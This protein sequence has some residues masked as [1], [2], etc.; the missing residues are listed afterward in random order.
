[1]VNKKKQ[2]SKST[3]RASPGK[4]KID[5]K[6]YKMMHTIFGKVDIP[7]SHPKYKSID[8]P[9]T[10][11]PAL[12]D[13]KKE[14][15]MGDE[16]KMLKWLAKQPL[17]WVDDD[18]EKNYLTLEGASYDHSTFGIASRQWD[19]EEAME[20][21]K[22]K[23]IRSTSRVSIPEVYESETEEVYDIL[24]DANF[25]GVINDLNN[26]EKKAII[27]LRREHPRMAGYRIMD[28]FVKKYPKM[29]RRLRKIMGDDD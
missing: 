16:V 18:G 28:L 2:R 13:R 25:H 12:P 24:E 3:C 5:P 11:K 15:A 8:R 19:L 1:M 22:T 9:L 26:A 21:A 23:K 27:K 17:Y 29:A 10:N 14:T 4:R 6:K 20:L 7:P